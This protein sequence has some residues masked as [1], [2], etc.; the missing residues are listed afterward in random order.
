MSRGDPKD[1]LIADFDFL[2]V[3]TGGG[4][5]ENPL[6]HEPLERA[7]EP[8]ATQR[9]QLPRRTGRRGGQPGGLLILEH[10]EPPQT[11]GCQGQMDKPISVAERLTKASA[12][13]PWPPEEVKHGYHQAM[14]A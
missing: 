8:L 7:V 12:W 4:S 3:R 9:R 11:A 6:Q 1:L 14:G 5:S 10:G 2:A 13:Y